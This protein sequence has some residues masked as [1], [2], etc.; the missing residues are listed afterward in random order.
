MVVGKSSFS[1]Q[2][3]E[4]EDCISLTSVLERAGERHFWLL[5][6]TLGLLMVWWFYV[7]PSECE[8]VCDTCM[9]THKLVHVG[10]LEN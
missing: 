1:K 8:H 9:C 6:W 2:R 4:V 5:D 7:G 10:T 3:Q